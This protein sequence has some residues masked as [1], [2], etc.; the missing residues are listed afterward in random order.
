MH[1]TAIIYHYF[2][3][4]RLPIFLELMQSQKVEFTLFSGIDSEI[5]INKIDTNLSKLPI[6]KGGLRWKFLKNY[7]LLNKRFLWQSDLLSL[8]LKS[9]FNSYIFLGSP[10]FITTWL[11]VLIVRLRGKKAYFWMHG[12]YK[13]KPTKI[14]WLKLYIFYKIPTGFFL[15][16]N[17]ALS[18]LRKYKVKPDLHM[19]VIYNSLDYKRSLKMRKFVIDDE[20]KN[21]RLSYFGSA[22]IPVI[23]FIG[24]LNLVKRIDMLI[25]AQ[26]FLKHS[27]GVIPFNVLLIGDGEERLKLEKQS[28]DLGLEEHVKFLGAIYDEEVN[29]NALLYA[30]LCVTPG[31]VGLTAMHAMSYGVPVISHNNFDVQMPEVEAIKVGVT[32][33]LFQYGDIESLSETIYCWLTNYPVKTNEVMKA[34]FSVIDTYY[35]PQYQKSVIESVLLKD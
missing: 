30:D 21:Y 3:T 2:A 12:V 28:I 10:Y 26:A 5:P 33:D 29:A 9:N 23:I 35:N 31:E 19:H 1:Q 14:D 13:N 34:C 15:Y 17:R 7:W 16:G 8:A 6:E 20:L 22:D 27:N 18:V 24:R 4:Y 32:G 11:A 25:N